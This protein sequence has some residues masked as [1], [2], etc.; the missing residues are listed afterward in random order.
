VTCPVIY[1][2]RDI[3][4]WATTLVVKRAGPVHIDVLIKAVFLIR[5]I[6]HRDTSARIWALKRASARVGAD[7]TCLKLETDPTVAGAL[8]VVLT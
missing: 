5:V 3:G 8:A 2:N 7:P 1:R 6:A 4:A